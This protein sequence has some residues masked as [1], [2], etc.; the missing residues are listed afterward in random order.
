MDFGALPPRVTW[1]GCMPNLA[2]HHR[3]PRRRLR[4]TG[5]AELSS[6]ATGYERR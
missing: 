1:C 3:S 6:V 2:R 5:Y 4:E